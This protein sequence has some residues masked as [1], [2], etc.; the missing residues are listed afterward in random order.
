MILIVVDIRCQSS[1]STPLLYSWKDLF[2]PQFKSVI[3]WS[4]ISYDHQFLL[5]PLNDVSFVLYLKYI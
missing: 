1:F 3:I 4:L 2:F 5:P